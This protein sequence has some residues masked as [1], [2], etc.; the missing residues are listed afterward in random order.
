MDFKFGVQILCVIPFAEMFL[1]RPLMV[2]RV[3]VHISHVQSLHFMPNLR[4]WDSFLAVAAKRY[5]LRLQ[6]CC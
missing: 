6:C 4:I 1:P 5:Y 2:C 3:K